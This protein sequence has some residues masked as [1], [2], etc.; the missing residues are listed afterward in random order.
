M[1]G[2]AL[3]F[4][5]LLATGL[6]VVAAGLRRVA[7]LDALVIAFSIVVLACLALGTV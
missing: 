6:S 4:L 1:M 5:L 2:L 7:V 3:W